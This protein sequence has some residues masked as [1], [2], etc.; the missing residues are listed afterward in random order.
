[1]YYL[2][3]F[4]NSDYLHDNQFIGNSCSKKANMSR[5]ISVLDIASQISMGI[6]DIV[7]LP[8][9]IGLPI[10]RSLGIVLSA[11]I[12]LPTINFLLKK[13][14]KFVFINLNYE[15]NILKKKY[16]L[17]KS[18][19]IL[20][21]FPIATPVY[22]AGRL[23]CSIILIAFDILGIALPEISRI[24]RQIYKN[25]KGIAQDYFIFFKEKI[26]VWLTGKKTNEISNAYKEMELSEPATHQVIRQQYKKLS[27]RYHPDKIRE[28]G[29]GDEKFTT[30]K[31]AHDL[32]LR[33][34][35]AIELFKESL[36]KH[37]FVMF[38]SEP[39]ENPSKSFLLMAP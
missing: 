22:I 14:I 31:A 28:I 3:A 6:Y 9:R 38:S 4:A 12:V 20:I 11:P 33:P 21:V 10:I 13:D 26:R 25:R 30:M 35:T 27:L 32:L 15:L 18:F 19:V 29:K 34:Q 7:S 5:L 16:D 17:K 2:N 1:M 39:Q 24:S 37:C 36:E 23:I 8:T